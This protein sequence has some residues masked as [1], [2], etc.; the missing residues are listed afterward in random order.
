[1][2]EETDRRAL[3][4]PLWWGALGL[5]VVNDHVL[6]GAFPGWWT[7]KISDFAGLLV[8]PVLVSALLAARTARMRALAFALP[9]AWFVAVKSVPGAGALTATIASHVGLDWTF[10]FD[11]TDLLALAVL[12]LA[13]H[14]ASHRGVIFVPR[15]W[16]ERAAVGAGVLA[17]MASPPPEPSWTTTAFLVNRTDRTLEVR[18][19]W[20]DA[21]VDCSL[22]QDRFA[23]I[24]ARDTFMAG[25]LFSVEPDHTLPLDRGLA[26]STDPWAP[27]VATGHN[28]SCDVVILTAEGMPET[29]VFWDGSAGPRAIPDIINDEDDLAQVE[30]GIMITEGEDERLAIDAGP[31]YRLA[32]PVDIYDDGAACRDYGAIAGFDWSSSLPLWSGATITLEEVREGID[33][34]MS[35]SYGES[36]GCGSDLDCGADEYC[37]F[38]SCC[39]FFGSCAPPTVTT[40]AF[41]CVPA[42]DFPFASGHTV[43]I[44]ND[45]AQLRIVRDLARED[46]STW[47]VGE[48]VVNRGSGT[49]REG[50]FDLTVVNVDAECQGVRMECGGF[51]VPGAGGI[52]LDSGGTRFVHPGEAMERD[53]ADGRRA[54]LRVGRAESMWV[55]HAAC[56]AGRD[57]LGSRLEALVVYAEET[58]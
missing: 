4:H 5:L 35:I 41:I 50:P 21:Q 53:A 2:M 8:A 57:V 28:G 19:R 52:A 14:V 49:F 44:W 1:M 10:A 12:P 33:G 29:M 15:I 27:P 38:G 9:T 51:R 11:P 24:L 13:W 42:S 58:R 37:D 55:T 45:G 30:G 47:R 31:M 36:G 16:T 7:G 40:S 23:E 56:G 6:K 46:G 39:D 17:C 18:V 3:R 48:L 20:V 22:I 43:Q 26:L 54:R 32:S 25:T 34:C